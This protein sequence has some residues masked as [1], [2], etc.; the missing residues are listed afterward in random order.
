MFT[1]QPLVKFFKLLLCLIVALACGRVVFIANNAQAQ[2]FNWTNA[3]IQ[4]NNFDRPDNWSPSGVPG[5]S[6]IGRFG[7]VGSPDLRVVS[8]NLQTG[9]LEVV[10]NAAVTFTRPQGLRLGTVTTFSEENGI[11][12]GLRTSLLVSGESPVLQ[13]GPGAFGGQSQI[14]AGGARIGNRRN[15]R[16][17]LI[18]ASGA[19]LNVTE[20][21]LIVGDDG[22]GNLEIRGGASLTT[23]TDGSSFGAFVGN[24]EGSLGTVR[25][26]G[27][28]A[29]W[30]NFAL[31]G[32]G[33]RVGSTGRLEVTNG[34]A[35]DVFDLGSVNISGSLEFGR[36]GHGTLSV[37]SGGSV[38]SVQGMLGAFGEGVARITGTGSQWAIAQDLTIGDRGTGI[39]SIEN[40][41]LVEVGGSIL[42]SGDGPLTPANASGS[43]VLSG[44]TLRTRSLTRGI[45]LSSFNW[46]GG[47]S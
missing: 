41:G 19:S 22:E 36:S 2:T 40:N 10:G 11:L 8:P 24:N 5:V 35:V 26:T 16:G 42:L 20:N 31:L 14:F 29:R 4:P 9:R 18:L 32:I 46:S 27:T 17:T 3:G 43:L 15:E 30:T 13:I 39:L 37:E 6:D 34:G 25:V 28:D 47:G 38:S 21:S 23:T 33:E 12:T 7:A 44:G 1:T 45:G